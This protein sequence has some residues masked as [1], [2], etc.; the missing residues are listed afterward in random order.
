ML[1]LEI[2]RRYLRNMSN[3]EAKQAREIGSGL[4]TYEGGFA[5]ACRCG[6]ALGAHDAERARVAGKSYQPCQEADCACE[7]F[8]PAKVARR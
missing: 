2:A 3:A 7:C 8:K 5:R 6:H 1:A 4:Y